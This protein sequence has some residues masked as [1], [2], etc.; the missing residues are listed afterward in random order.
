MTLIILSAAW[1]IGIAAA[2]Y[3]SPPL[4]PSA[5]L[6]AGLIGLLAVPPLAAL[7]LWRDDAQVRPV[8]TCGLYL[9]LGSLRYAL[10]VPVL[11]DPGHIAVYRGQGEMTLWGKV[12]G[13]PGVRDTYTN[14]GLAVDRVQTD[15]E[16]QLVN[17][18][19]LVRARR[20][21]A[22][23]YG[24]ELEAEGEPETPPVFDGFS[25]RDYLARQRIH[26][27][28]GWPKITLLSRG[29]GSP[30]HRA[31][32]ILRS[33]TQTPIAH[34]LPQPEASLL[35]GILLGVESGIPERVKDA[36]PA[37]GTTHVIAIS[38]FN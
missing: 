1:L 19:V 12:A 6:R 37:T 7:I 36:F 35:T 32:L 11:T 21:A 4:A 27:T 25:Y 22:Y 38:G 5:A 10:S 15:G 8:A 26:G 17:G 9:L 23:I 2:R 29:G 14:L 24:D 33:R 18:N 16:E 20:Y 3:V 13:E 28:V 31:V 34:V 30:I